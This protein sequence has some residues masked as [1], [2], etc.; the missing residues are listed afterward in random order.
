MLKQFPEVILDYAAGGVISPSALGCAARATQLEQV[1]R[2][3]AGAALGEIPERAEQALRQARLDGHAK[4]YVDAVL[5]AVP[6]LVNLLADAQ[7]L[8]AS[9]RAQLQQVLECSLQAEGVAHELIVNRC[10]RAL[11]G[12]DE[13][14]LYLPEKDTLLADALREGLSGLDGGTRVQL[15]ATQSPYPALKAGPLMA[16]LDPVGPLLAAIDAPVDTAVLEAAAQQHAMT[17]ATE[18]NATLR[19]R[20]ARVVSPVIKD[21]A[22]EH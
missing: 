5:A 12:T 14:T 11:A 13:I 10:R 7:Q 8:R 1:A 15:R 20:A 16:E 22:H 17:Y 4:G 9:L 21:P 19:R 3:R 18:F 6:H 2:Q